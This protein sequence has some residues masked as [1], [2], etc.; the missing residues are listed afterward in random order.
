MKQGELVARPQIRQQGADQMAPY[1]GVRG[2]V[3]IGCDGW[4]FVHL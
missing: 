1:Q 3:G 2:K 4:N